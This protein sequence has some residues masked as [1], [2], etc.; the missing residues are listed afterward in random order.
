V[1]KKLIASNVFRVNCCIN[2]N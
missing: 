1:I 2:C